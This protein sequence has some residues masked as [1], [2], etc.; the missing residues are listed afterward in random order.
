MKLGPVTKFDKKNQIMPKKFDDDVMY[1]NCDVIVL[2]LIYGHFGAIRKLQSPL[3][4][5]E[6]LK[7]PPRLGLKL[8]SYHVTS[9]IMLLKS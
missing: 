1:P 4:Q 3:I 9:F 6:P 2:F 7:T 8:Q 5:N